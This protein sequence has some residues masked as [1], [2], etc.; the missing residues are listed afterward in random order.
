MFGIRKEFDS[1]RENIG[2]FQQAQRNFFLF[3]RKLFS[4]TQP[5][6]VFLPDDTSL[7]DIHTK[8]GYPYGNSHLSCQV[9]YLQRSDYWER[10]CLSIPYYAQAD[11][12]GTDFLLPNRVYFDL[13]TYYL[14]WDLGY[15]RRYADNNRPEVM[16]K[17]RLGLAVTINSTGKVDCWD[18][19]QAKQLVDY[20][21]L[22]DQV[23]SY[24]GL[25]FDNLVLSAYSTPE[26]I[27]KLT[28]KTF[29]LYQYLQEVRGSKKTL[30]QWTERYLGSGNFAKSLISDGLGYE[31]KR[32]IQGFNPNNS[33]PFILREGATAQRRLI[34][35]A[36]F[37]DVINTRGVYTEL[38]L[39]QKFRGAEFKTD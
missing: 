17:Q 30:L 34:W 23:V 7:T 11:S 16:P 32:L 1:E 19:C 27:L 13:E 14:P 35:V 10:G 9:D 8:A 33:I 26:Q 38:Q 25:R 12:P 2:N 18:E 24:N 3:C 22:Y 28:D 21:L 39:E 37:E 31:E 6:L 36:C 20:L 4:G 15:S 29:D 5:E